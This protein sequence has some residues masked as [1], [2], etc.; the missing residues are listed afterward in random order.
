MTVQIP[1][2][3]YFPTR[4]ITRILTDPDSYGPVQQKML[5]GLLEMLYSHRRRGLHRHLNSPRDDTGPNKEPGISLVLDYWRD[6]VEPGVW[7]QQYE[8]QLHADGNTKVGKIELLLTEYGLFE[9]ANQFNSTDR[10][11]EGRL[12]FTADL[13]D[14]INL[15]RDV[16]P[17]EP[18]S[19]FASP[20]GTGLGSGNVGAADGQGGGGGRGADGAPPDGPDGPDGPEGDGGSGLRDVVAHPVLFSNPDRLL[21]IFDSI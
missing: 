18:P 5:A 10:Y 15:N 7:S 2:L 6:P 12:P 11:P 1:D 4:E 16:D 9:R 3:N 21:A 13:R 14:H 8:A 19:L 17:Y 20:L